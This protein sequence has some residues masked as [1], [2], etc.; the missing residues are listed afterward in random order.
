MSR[1]RAGD[2]LIV[3]F[4]AG[5]LP[6]EPN[7]IRPAV[8]IDNDM[9]FADDFDGVFVAPITSD[10]RRVHP[11]F[12]VL[13]EPDMQN[14]CKTRSWVLGNRATAV[15]PLRCRMTEASITTEQ[16]QLVR[17]RVAYMM[18]FPQISPLLASFLEARPLFKT[19]A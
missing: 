12:A 1:P 19:P 11:L 16:L 4:R 14:R 17:Q 9:L 18:G 2:I 8:V 15:S 3:D 13:L 6:G 7:K 10:E 5:A